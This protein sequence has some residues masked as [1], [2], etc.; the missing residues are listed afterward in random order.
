MTVGKG[1]N[2]VELPVDPNLS[3]QSVNVL[4]FTY[5]SLLAT[6]LC[7]FQAEGHSDPPINLVI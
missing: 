2:A 7:I 6:Y 4:N 3:A 1:Q 5:L